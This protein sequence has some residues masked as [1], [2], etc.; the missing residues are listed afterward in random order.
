MTFNGRAKTLREL[1]TRIDYEDLNP[2]DEEDK[3]FLIE[4]A[5]ILEGIS[6]NE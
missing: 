4:T 5:R 2:F 6:P 3:E 1:A